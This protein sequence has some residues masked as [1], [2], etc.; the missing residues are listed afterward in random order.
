MTEPTA[1]FT[2][3]ELLELDEKKIHIL[4]HLIQ[5]EIATNDHV[6]EVLRDAVRAKYDQLRRS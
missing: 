1:L 6:R 4:K 5:R 2:L 3:E